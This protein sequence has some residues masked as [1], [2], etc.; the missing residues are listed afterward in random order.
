MGLANKTIILGI[1]ALGIL[2]N[3][4]FTTIGGSKV[5]GGGTI[6]GNPILPAVPLDPQHKHTPDP[7]R[8]DDQR[9]A[10]TEDAIFLARM[11]CKQILATILRPTTYD[12]LL[13]PLAPVWRRIGL[14]NGPKP[15]LIPNLTAPLS[16]W[17]QFETGL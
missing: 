12:I 5:N 4:C 7:L 6:I 9:P 13:E 11:Q 16:F 3:G 8:P 10:D 17:E 2:L 14:I 1:V 15:P